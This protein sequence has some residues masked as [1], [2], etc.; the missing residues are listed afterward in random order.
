MGAVNLGLC[1]YILFLQWRNKR[2]EGAMEGAFRMMKDLSEGNAVIEKTER[3]FT[4][5]RV[6]K[7]GHE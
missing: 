2:L 1:A 5:R 7:D 4:V 3:G 6:K